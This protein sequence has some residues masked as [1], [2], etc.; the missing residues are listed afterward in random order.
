VTKHFFSIRCWLIQK[1]S[2]PQC[3]F[4]YPKTST[5]RV[6]QGNVL[7]TS[8][9]AIR[10][11]IL[12][13]ERMC[14]TDQGQLWCKDHLTSIL[15]NLNFKKR[16]YS[17]I[18]N[19]KRSDRLYITKWTIGKYSVQIQM[20]LMLIKTLTLRRWKWKVPLIK[21]RTTLRQVSNYRKNL[22]IITNKIIQHP[23]KY[24]NSFS[25]ATSAHVEFTQKLRKN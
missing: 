12:G 23:V 22:L 11:Q 3:I 10:G 5:Q 20:I 15:L 14:T 16:I 9:R 8:C 6:W 1:Q 2:Q 13:R 21:L 7:Y 17:I 18:V 4:L 25:C 24:I 19:K